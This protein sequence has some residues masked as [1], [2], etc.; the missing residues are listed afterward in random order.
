MLF[1]SVNWSM[2][3]ISREAS[4]PGVSRWLRFS[5]GCLH[6]N[7]SARRSTSICRSSIRIGCPAETKTPVPAA[8]RPCCPRAS[9]SSLTRDGCIA[10]LLHLV[11]L[12][13]S[14]VTMA[15]IDETERVS[16]RPVGAMNLLSC[17]LGP[18]Q[19]LGCFDFGRDGVDQ[20]DVVDQSHSCQPIAPLRIWDRNSRFCILCL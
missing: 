4:A 2:G 11:E 14:A 1:R 15:L 8:K 9:Q 10:P 12:L 18:F 3:S 16:S 6:S 13:G 7:C 20:S 5:V 17:E 19:A